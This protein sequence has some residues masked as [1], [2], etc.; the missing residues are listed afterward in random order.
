[1]HLEVSITRYFP[2]PNAQ[3]TAVNMYNW[4]Y[5]YTKY[6]CMQSFIC[7]YTY[8]IYFIYFHL[9]IYIN[10]S[11]YLLFVCLFV[12]SFIYFLHVFY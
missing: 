4:T 12:Y 6:V 2:Y 7:T 5:T 8:F 10:N 3:F 9:L 1:M 11:I